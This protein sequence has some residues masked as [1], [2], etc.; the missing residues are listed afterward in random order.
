MKKIPS[1]AI[2]LKLEVRRIGSPFEMK[3]KIRRKDENNQNDKENVDEGWIGAHEL[4]VGVEDNAKISEERVPE[5]CSKK[6]V[7]KEGSE[8]H[9]ANTCWD[10]DEV[11]Y[12]R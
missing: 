12:Y 6:R 1:P 9:V 2:I 10:G 5:R 4:P 7:K 3:I 11:S 8:L